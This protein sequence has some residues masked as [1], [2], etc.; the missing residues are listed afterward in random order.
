[1]AR[2]K[3]REKSKNRT[4]AVANGYSSDDRGTANGGLTEQ[5]RYSDTI[6]VRKRQQHA[7]D[8]KRK[9]GRVESTDARAGITSSGSE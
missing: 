9:E 8:K 4:R 5:A 7:G 3:N 2:S 6:L 1:M